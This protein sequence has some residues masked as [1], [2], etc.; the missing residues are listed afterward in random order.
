MASKAFHK[1]NPMALQ[2]AWER[3]SDSLN[4]WNT[5]VTD[6]LKKNAIAEY[7]Y[8][9][10][11]T[12]EAQEVISAAQPR[13]NS[14]WNLFATYGWTKEVEE[15]EQA[16]D[17]PKFPDLAKPKGQK[18]AELCEEYYVANGNQWTRLSDLFMYLVSKGVM[19][20][21]KNPN[22]TLSAH[23]SNSDR[24]ESDRGKGWRLKGPLYAIK[25]KLMT[26]NNSG[27]LR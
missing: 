24:F 19:I 22:S 14:L 25:I 9:S 7:K 1:A 4:R 8:L 10:A 11:Q 13:I 18:I 23:L 20:S 27:V 21:G 16:D 5:P 12:A 6:D 2:R 26:G 3:G 17:W 15:I